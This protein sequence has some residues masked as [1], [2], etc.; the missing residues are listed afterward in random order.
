M[1]AALGPDLIRWRTSI[2][3]L[4]NE[5]AHD[6]KEDLSEWYNDLPLHGLDAYRSEGAVAGC[7]AWPALKELGEMIQYP[8]ITIIFKLTTKGFRFRGGFRK[9]PRVETVEV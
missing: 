5:R 2:I 9:R 7:V 8:G 6:M 3:E 1:A 4:M